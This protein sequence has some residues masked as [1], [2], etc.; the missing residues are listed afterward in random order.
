MKTAVVSPVTLHHTS[1]V[2]VERDS[3]CALSVEKPLV[4]VHERTHTGEKPHKCKECG[5]AFSHRS[6]LVVHRRIH[7]RVK[8]V[9]V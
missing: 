6:N 7:T 3:T 8:A 4:T 5:K 9:H 2:M 1:E